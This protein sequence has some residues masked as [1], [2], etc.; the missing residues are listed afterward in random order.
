MKFQK[1]RKVFRQFW[2]TK[3]IVILLTQ[4]LEMLVLK[5]T[6]GE[7]FDILTQLNIRRE[8]IAHQEKTTSSFFNWQ[9]SIQSQFQI[10]RA[11]VS[12]KYKKILWIQK[13][14]KN[15]SFINILKEQKPWTQEVRW[16]PQLLLRNS[17][18]KKMK[19]QIHNHPKKII[20]I[21]WNLIMNFSLSVTNLH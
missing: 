1:V 2:T 14:D 4:I 13:S 8:S 20:W 15:C 19:K 17:K 5:M 9:I 10:T 3:K 6:S 18:L 12:K 16:L 11:K 7:W 21:N